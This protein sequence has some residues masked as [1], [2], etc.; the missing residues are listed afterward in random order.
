MKIMKVSN[1]IAFENFNRFQNFDT[2][3]ER[4]AIFAYD[5]DVYRNI[6]RKTFSEEMFN[7]AQKHLRIIWNTTSS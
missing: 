2:M 4:Q 3:P 5:G 1:K 6:D 7:L